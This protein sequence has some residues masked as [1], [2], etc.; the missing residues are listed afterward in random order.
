[1]ITKVVRDKANR[2]DARFIVDDPSEA[3]LQPLAWYGEQIYTA[4]AIVAHFSPH[5]RRGA[6][7]HNARC[8]L[9][10]GLAVGMGKP[11]LMLAE[12]DYLAPVD[13]R[14]LL[15]VYRSAKD[16]RAHVRDWLDPT[17]R[18]ARGE[19]T[20]T[21]RRDR[22]IRLA[23]ELKSLRFGEHIAENEAS[24]LSSYFVETGHYLKVLE[25]RT[26]IFSGRKGSG[27]SANLLRAAQELSEDKRNLVC[28]I[29]PVGYELEGIIRLLRKYDER[30][31][32]TFLVE[33]LWK[34]LLYTQM[35][36]AVVD[37]L[38][39]TPWAHHESSPEWTL[40][41]Y[42]QAHKDFFE[43][44]FSLRLE[45]AISNMMSITP[46]DTIAGDRAAITSA[47]HENVLSELR[48][49]LGSVLTNKER[50]AILIDNLD[51]AWERAADIEHLSF[52]LLGLLSAI[53]RVEREFSKSSGGR[54]P[55]PVTLAV[56][57]RTDILQRVLKLAREPDKLP[58]DQLSWTD[59]D[60]LLRV[61]EERYAS[62]KNRVTEVPDLWTT[63]FEPQI[64]HVDTRTYISNA[65]LKRP[66]DI[67]YFCNA[68]VT[69]AINRR[70]DKVRVE[71]IRDAE[72]L[73]S[74]FAFEVLLVEGSV[75]VD[76][77]E[78]IIYEFVGEP[79][80]LSENRVKQIVRRAGVNNDVSEVITHLKNLSFLGV[81]TKRGTF[82][83]SEDRVERRKAEKLAGRLA[84]RT[85]TPVQFKIHPAFHNF[86]EVDA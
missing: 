32:K 74:Q 71:D 82:D 26:T 14:D 55:V 15:H 37:E 7:V 25:P 18:T 63:F 33:A 35:A 10:S 11:L 84:R 81:E 34:F 39:K 1:M 43:P 9:A 50:V 78:E 59:R 13:Y 30:D 42:V 28:V 21:S 77:L 24:M 86:L 83:F 8:A 2:E 62:A 52:F 20:T 5:R 73:Y 66:R 61:V 54:L 67:V 80:V 47:L 79:S 22:E 44:D 49:L 19:L 65:V 3:S 69:A 75:I 17:V 12:E 60:L 48:R 40:I 56:F 46:Q 45:T 4:L 16:A 68:A 41:N 70:H 57:V 38:E 58:I 76:A 23:T 31:S 72:H 6:D 27:K 53:K 85:R 51:K 36:I 29:K 64:D